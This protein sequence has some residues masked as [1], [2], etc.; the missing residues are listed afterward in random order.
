VTMGTLSAL[1]SLVSR[2][3]ANTVIVLTM[4]SFEEIRSGLETV[5]S[6]RNLCWACASG[7]SNLRGRQESQNLRISD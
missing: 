4:S 5:S 3:C 2:I 6:A 1:M 7:L